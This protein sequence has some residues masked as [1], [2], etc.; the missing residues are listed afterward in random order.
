MVLNHIT[1]VQRNA[2]TYAA[3]RALGVRFAK[4][5][6]IYDYL[7]SNIE[8]KNGNEVLTG[9]R[10]ANIVMNTRENME[11]ITLGRSGHFIDSEQNYSDDTQKLLH[12]HLI[13]N[14]IAH[15]YDKLEPETFKEYA[16]MTIGDEQN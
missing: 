16:R 7:A 6:D 15:D 10:L 1:G 14:V 9:E 2:L 5:E 11:G 12:A 13:Q 8:N 4:G 3:A